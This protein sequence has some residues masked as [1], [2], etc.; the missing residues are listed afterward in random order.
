MRPECPCVSGESTIGAVRGVR[1]RYR[2]RRSVIRNGEDEGVDVNDRLPSAVVVNR[3]H[4]RDVVQRHRRP[5][6]P[7]RSV[8]SCH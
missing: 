5:R 7:R 4:C 6:R 1:R 8:I 3:C 2:R